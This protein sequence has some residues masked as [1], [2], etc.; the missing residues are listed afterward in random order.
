MAIESGDLAEWAVWLAALVGIWV[1]VSPY[2]YE[3]GASARNNSI[4]AGIVVAVLAIYAGYRIRT[5]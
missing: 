5:A 2:V 1:A 3:M 4:G